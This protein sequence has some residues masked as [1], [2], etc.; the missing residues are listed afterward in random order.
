MPRE[1]PT[2]VAV[3]VIVVVVLIAAFAIWRGTGVRKVE[4]AP[5]EMPGAKM[6]KYGAPGPMIPKGVPT[7]P[8]PP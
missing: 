6:G 2:W 5:E 3:L 4:L 8:T 1:I 7:Q